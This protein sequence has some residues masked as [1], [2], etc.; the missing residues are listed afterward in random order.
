M[1]DQFAFL[2]GCRASVLLHTHT[3][4]YTYSTYNLYAFV[5]ANAHPRVPVWITYTKIGTYLRTDETFLTGTRYRC[6]C[7]CYRCRVVN[8]DGDTS[9]DLGTRIPVDAFPAEI[10]QDNWFQLDQSIIIN[11]FV[12]FVGQ[13]GMFLSFKLLFGISL[14]FKSYF[15]CIREYA[16]CFLFYIKVIE[17]WKFYCRSTWLTPNCLYSK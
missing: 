14:S 13:F 17:F 1:K 2:E 3:H 12:V 11:S 4:T 16:L 5:Y 9:T 10:S 15:K 8:I 6:C 7:C